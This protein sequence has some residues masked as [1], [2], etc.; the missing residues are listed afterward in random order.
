MSGTTAE[1][2]A[3]AGFNRPKLGSSCCLGVEFNRPWFGSIDLDEDGV[4]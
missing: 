3:G 1:V 4:G 2:G